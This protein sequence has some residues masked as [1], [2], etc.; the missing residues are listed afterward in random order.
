MDSLS[1]EDS[2]E[3]LLSRYIT[4]YRPRHYSPILERNQPRSITPSLS[5]GSDWNHS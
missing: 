4:T 5:T 1:E 2:D 3:D